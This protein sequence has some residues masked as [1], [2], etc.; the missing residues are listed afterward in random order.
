M[1]THSG[2]WACL[3][4]L[5]P[6]PLFKYCVPICEVAV[7]ESG[8]LETGGCPFTPFWENRFGI[9]HMEASRQEGPGH[10]RLTV[11]ESQQI[12]GKSGYGFWFG[13]TS[14]FFCFSFSEAPGYYLRAARGTKEDLN[15]VATLSC[16]RQAEHNACE[17]TEEEG[18]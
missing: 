14:C 11:S 1:R 15:S 5:L 17:E 18:I 6:L 10:Y 13:L 16:R 2:I 8:W 12:T 9:V 4:L 7:G 3:T